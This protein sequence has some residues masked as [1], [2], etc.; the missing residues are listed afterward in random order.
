MFLSLSLRREAVCRRFSDRSG[1][2]TLRLN[3]C[4]IDD[5]VPQAGDI[6]SACAS[7]TL[8]N[9]PRV[10]KIKGLVRSFS[11]GITGRLSESEFS[12][13]PH[14]RWEDG[15][16]FALFFL[17][18]T[19]SYVVVTGDSRAMHP[20]LWLHAERRHQSVGENGSPCPG[21]A[22]PIRESD[23]LLKFVCAGT[24]VV[25]T[26]VSASASVGVSVSV[27]AS[28]GSVSA[29]ASGS[30]GVSVSVQ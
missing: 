27:S 10:S 30:V 12:T 5:K 23:I 9:D 20:A 4:G 1:V 14:V 3:E 11:E 16:S 17:G 8:A 28:V 7:L 13:G 15:H 29:D 22:C 2:R 25:S 19:L 18:P 24:I 21:M 26:S 6:R